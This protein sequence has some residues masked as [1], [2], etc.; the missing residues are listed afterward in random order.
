MTSPDF[1]RLQYL[2]LEPGTKNLLFMQKDASVVT[3]LKGVAKK[4][5]WVRIEGGSKKLVAKLTRDVTSMIGQKV[6]GKRS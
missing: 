5:G 1:G 6:F 4:I 3:F 2:Q